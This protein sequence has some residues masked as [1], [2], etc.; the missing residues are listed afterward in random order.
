MNNRVVQ[1]MFEQRHFNAK[2]ADAMG[3]LHTHAEF[4]AQRIAL[5]VPS[6]EY[7]ARALMKVRDAIYDCEMAFTLSPICDAQTEMPF[8]SQGES[9]LGANKNAPTGEIDTTKLVH[10]ARK[11]EEEAHELRALAAHARR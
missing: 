4:L 6:G 11:L 10:R 1:K 2:E 8:M 3:D 5:R 7:Q 9:T